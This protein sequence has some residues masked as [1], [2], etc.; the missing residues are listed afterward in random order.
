MQD[1]QADEDEYKKMQEAERVKQAKAKKVQENV[2]K[3]REQNARRKLDKVRPR[4]R[5]V[6]SRRID[7]ACSRSRIVSGTP[8]SRRVNGTSQRK[9]KA[10]KTARRNRSSLSTS[11]VPSA[12]VDEEADGAGGE[13]EESHL[14]HLRRRRRRMLSPRRRRPTRALRQLKPSPRAHE[15]N[16]YPCITTILLY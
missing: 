15:S 14:L 10:Q 6:P 4:W 16:V 5:S 7:P 12:G 1:V 13:E 8:A 11:V 3:A 9:R 2:D